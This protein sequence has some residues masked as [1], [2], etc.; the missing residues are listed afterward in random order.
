MAIPASPTRADAAVPS[1][2][3]TAAATSDPCVLEGDGEPED[4]LLFHQEPELLLYGDRADPRPLLRVE[5]RERYTLHGRWSEL[6]AATGDGRARLALSRVGAF[7]IEGYAELSVTRFRLRRLS[8]VVEG[9]V[10][11][12]PD[13]VVRLVGMAGGR[14]RVTAGVPFESP[15]E[16][17]L[18]VRCEDLAYDNKRERPQDAHED[19][20]RSHVERLQLH[21]APNGP[22]VFD[23]A[24]HL[25]FVAVDEERAGFLKIHGERYGVRI[26]G[27]TPRALVSHEPRGSGGPSGSRHGRRSGSKG[28][29]ARVLRR[30]PL[31][32][33]REAV[34][35]KVGEIDA[36]G[37]VRVLGPTGSAGSVAVEL[38]SGDVRPV[39]GV[40]LQVDAADLA[41]TD[42]S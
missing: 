6:P 10:W 23:A 33:V 22:V 37:A 31:L 26:A 19:D 41:A 2:M 35:V 11:L 39:D 15:R 36:G 18:E 24:S 34:R 28:K 1:A 17:A 20:A 12:E 29:A 16:L 40:T 7:R 3:P 27:W 13:F 21:A 38:V 42:S 14:A 9:H 4:Q 30:T 25:F 5:G 32:A 8:P